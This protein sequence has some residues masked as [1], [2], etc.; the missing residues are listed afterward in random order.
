MPARD[1]ADVAAAHEELVRR[2]L[3]VGRV[4]AQRREEEL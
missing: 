3:R 4:V 2:G 1:L